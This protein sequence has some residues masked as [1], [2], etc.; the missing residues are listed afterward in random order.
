MTRYEGAIRSFESKVFLAFSVSILVVFG[1]VA[2]TWK[3]E[4]DAAEA[5]TL[6]L[7]A[8]NVLYRVG[9]VAIDTLQ[10]ELSSQDFGITGDAAQRV[11]RDA[12]M[13]SRAANMAQLEQ[14]TADNPAEQALLAQLNATIQQRVAMSRQIEERTTTRGRAVAGADAQAAQLKET[15]EHVKQILNALNANETQVLNQRLA[16]QSELRQRLFSVGAA[17]ALALLLLLCATFVL[18]RRQLQTARSIRRALAQSEE[19]YATTLLSIGDAVVATDT[20][21]RI[22]RMNRVAEQLT[23]WTLEAARGRPIADIFVI[24]HETTRDSAVIPVSQ[25]LATGE[26]QQLANHTVLI[27]RD[28]SEH[29]IADS[30][31]PIRDY[32]GH[33]QGVVLVFRDVS[34][35]HAAEQAILEHN[36]QL[37]RRVEQRTHQLQESELRYRTAFMTI[38]DAVVLTRLADGLL[39]D[40]NE[41][42]TRLFG[43]PNDQ[44][45]GRTYPELKIWQDPKLRETM[46][47]RIQTEGELRDLEAVLLT[48]SGQPVTTLVTA[49]M[50]SLQG[51]ACVL[52]V[53]RDITDSKRMA[54]AL[55]QSEQQ[56][57][58]MAQ[59]MPQ[60]VWICAADGANIYFNQ[61]WV[62]YTGMSLE[63]S[64]GSGWS[65]T[66]HPDD[67]D[68][69]WTAWDTAVQQGRMYTRECRLRRFDGQYQWWLVRGVP[70]KD[71]HGAVYRWYGTCTHIDDIKRSEM[72]LR[73]SKERLTVTLESLRESQNIADLGSYELDIESGVWTSSDV[74][75]RIFGLNETSERTIASWLALIHP[76]H[77]DMM[78]TYLSQEVLGKGQ[79]FDRE[80]Q[81]VRQSDH[82]ARWVYGRGKLQHNAFGQIV[83]LHGTIQDITER[84]TVE[85]AL[86]ESENRYRALVEQALIG[87]YVIQD[88]V[89]KYVNA[90]LATMFGYDT[91]HAL[92][93]KVQALH[94]VGEKD[95][96]RVLVNMQRRLDGE[97]VALHYGFTGVRQDGQLISLDLHGQAFSYHGRPALLGMIFDISAQKKSEEQL[98]I[99][100]IAFESQE[101]ILVTNAHAVIQQVNQAFTRITG[102]T[103]DD[104]VGQK[105]SILRSGRHEP[106][107]YTRMWETILKDGY[108]QGEL[109]NCHKSG[110]QFLERLSISAVRDPG[111]AI[112]H[113]VGTFSDVTLQ[114]EIESKVH[115]LAYYDALTDLPNRLLLCD[116]LEHVLA[117]SSRTQEYGALLFVDLDNFKNVN[118]TLGHHA[119]DA[120]LKQVAQRMRL[121][122]RDGDTVARFGGDEFVVTL[123]KL[124]IEPHGA[125]KLAQQIGDALLAVL[126]Q[127]YELAGQPS[128]CTASIGATLFRGGDD[129]VESILM[130]A[131]MAMYRAKVEGRNRLRF[132][133]Q[134]MQT[135]LNARTALE[136]EIRV[137]VEQQQ[138]VLYYQ[139]QIDLAGHTI[140]AEA[141]VRWNHPQR[142]LLAPGVFIPVAEDTGLILSLGQW[143]LD[144][145][146]AQIS[147]WAQSPLT[148]AL[149]L[150]VNVSAR[151]FEQPD[152]VDSVLKSLRHAGANPTRLKLEIT[153]SIVLN[154]IDD[155]GL[156]MNGL[157]AHGIRFSLDDF[158]T[159]SS[160]LSYLTRLPL[161]QLKIDKSFVDKLPAS[162]QDALVV[163]TIIAMGKGLG[164]DVI[165]EGVETEEQRAFL[166]QHHCDAFQGFHF[167]KAVPSEQFQ[168]FL[169]AWP[170]MAPMEVNP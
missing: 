86:R 136:A 91:P 163:Q 29:P 106:A 160:S 148:C 65:T 35:E 168:E 165:A 139:P 99:A 116:R 1:L 24:V 5:D 82:V 143:V 141:L 128:Y 9:H 134:T 71:S 104:V 122:V 162:T 12:A 25:V 152:F 158:G 138:F 103:A 38:P 89:F 90:S 153:E 94:L 75:D 108:W 83:Q 6:V 88:G 92:I 140:G 63:A 58:L 57:R 72:E 105:P 146:C 113:F 55:E 16:T 93:D 8:R 137:G 18:I 74:L 32:Q 17:T 4:R 37:E 22:V 124:G 112:S 54:D 43:W 14:L 150:A 107:F 48:R 145:A 52:A 121:A 131:D 33:I 77:H 36:Q 115:H 84:K 155:A 19:S 21:S 13:A 96:A 39:L 7:H 81:I 70:A 156:K 132:F 62:D 154:N 79:D 27:A 144:T 23:G 170:A 49:R 120:L 15:R 45:V 61:Q 76:E 68:G 169:R 69:M 3:L 41:G 102:F 142:G 151:Q 126:A 78:A 31:A 64:C 87:I 26:I 101:G 51:D 60:I 135:E 167:S 100:A 67:Q 130:H 95:R 127:R 28:G 129:A 110:K 125:A 46:V 59:A 80:Y 40:V 114:R 30:A 34:D 147:A 73:W 2:A 123:E 66:I 56:F 159:G 157:K 118:D 149:Q 98:R 44:V 50:I 53:V 42:F 164:L 119:G 117:W 85:N 11:E 47:Q 109:W 133:E 10:F 111:G 97:P 161:D 166:T 20:Q